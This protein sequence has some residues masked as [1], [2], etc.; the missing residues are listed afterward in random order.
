MEV[1]RI[2]RDKYAES[3]SGSLSENRWNVKGEDVI[4]AGSSR[5]LSTLEVLVHQNFV[6]PVFVHKVSVIRLPDDLDFYRVIHKSELP[7]GHDWRFKAAYA[8]LQKI[9][10]DWYKSKE[11]LILKVPSAVITTE[12]NYVINTQHPDFKSKVSIADIEDY[13]WDDRLFPGKI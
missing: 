11:T 2:S 4:Y 7:S 8:A 3:L 5:A 9:G 13:F 6:K 10:S 12:Y 1:Y